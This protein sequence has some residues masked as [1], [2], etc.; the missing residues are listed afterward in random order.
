MVAHHAGTRRPTIASTALK[1]YRNGVVSM[2]S[3]DRAHASLNREPTPPVTPIRECLAGT[4]E[5]RSARL[6]RLPVFL[7]RLNMSL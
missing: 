7:Q 4:Q 6:T 5:D 1:A 3:A 2:Q